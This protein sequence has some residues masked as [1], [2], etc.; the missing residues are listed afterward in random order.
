[1]TLECEWHPIG[2][3]QSGEH[4]PAGE[5]PELPGSQNRLGRFVNTVVVKNETVEHQTILSRSAK[6]YT[7]RQMG[8]AEHYPYRSAEARAKFLA[9]YDQIAEDWPIPSESRMVSTK[10][11]ETFVRIGGPLDAP[12]LVLLPGMTATSL[13][14]APNI[15]ALSA[16]YRT[17][18]IDRNGDIGRST[19]T[20]RMADAEDAVNWLDELFSGLAPGDRINLA[21]L[22]FGGWLTAQYALRFPQRLRSVVLIAPGGILPVSPQFVWRGLL[23]LTSRYFARRTIRWLMADLARTNPARIELSLNRLLLAIKSLRR[24]RPMPIKLLADQELRALS[25]P[26]LYLVGEHEKI[27]PA[28]KAIERLKRVAP[29]IRT[30]MVPQAGHDLTI[31]QAERVNRLILDFL[32]Q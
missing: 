4:A 24:V 31:V 6:C 30:A 13:L 8:L 20:R 23:L 3:L 10:F 12:P 22:S 17:Y 32:R 21:G 29:N 28:A 15:S 9:S 7:A 11:G 1:M 16:Q 18:A 2:N 25:V 19:C 26:A 27:Y 5:Q 14:W